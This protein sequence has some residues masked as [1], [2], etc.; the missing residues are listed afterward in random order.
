MIITKIIQIVKRVYNYLKQRW[1]ADTPLIWQRIRTS[2]ISIGVICGA[3]LSA[4]R[5]AGIEVS[6]R[7]TDILAWGI[8]IGAA[9]AA[10]SQL[11][12][13]DKIK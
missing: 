9:V 5:T 11:Q 13:S 4:E 12:K 2:A 7:T 10:F 1:I 6:E 8:G 3:I